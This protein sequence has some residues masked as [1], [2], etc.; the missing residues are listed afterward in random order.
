VN[1]RAHEHVLAIT[2]NIALALIAAA[3][4]NAAAEGRSSRPMDPRHIETGFKI[5][6]E[7]YCDQPYVIVND[8][9]SWTCVLTTGK[10][11]EGSRGQHIVSTISG[12]RGKTWS[13]LVDIE[14]A[15]GPESSWVVPLKAA[16][17]RIYAFYTYN[18]DNIRPGRSDT[19]G[20]YCYKYSDDNGRSWSAERYRIPM[21]ETAA[22][23][24]NGLPK[25][26][27]HFW[28]IDKPSVVD[29]VVY[30]AFTKLG[31]YF[32]GNGEGWVVKS[33]NIMTEKDPAKINWRILPDGDHG[34][35]HPDYGSIQEEHNI[36]PMSHESIYCVY[37]TTRGFPAVTISRDA[38]MTWTVPTQMRYSPGKRI[39]RTP[40]ACPKLWKCA[41]GKYLFWFHNNSFNHFYA[42]NPA[43]LIG[44]EERNGTIHWSEPEILLYHN[45]PRGRGTI[46]RGMSYPDLI[47]QDGRYWVTETVKIVAR[48]HEL[49]TTLL[50]GLWSQGKVKEVA[51][52]GL[53][54]AAGE[55]EI[56]SGSATL[57]GVDIAATA[58]MTIDFWIQLDDTSPGQTILDSRDGNG[59]GL[60]V[61][62]GNNG[63]IAIELDDGSSKAKWDSDAGLIKSDRR[64]HVAIVVDD[65]PRIV[66]FVIDGAFC[67]GRGKRQFGWTR[68]KTHLGDVTGSGTL[69]LANSLEE[70][71]V[72]GRYLR[73]SEVVA[74]YNAGASGR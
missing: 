45:T 4:I 18:G 56:A 36:V 68:Y 61:S 30:F 55:K 25:G 57:T 46:G 63:T 16:T 72:Y 26:C 52:R 2:R 22:D 71:R 67:D 50:E 20:W 58:G 48:V 44:G 24:T 33:D 21:R 51:S 65:G 13:P 39:V 17:G 34:L 19:H 10:G 74:N 31:K 64:H 12:N 14:P 9:A 32:L 15:T 29:G 70:L 40:R 54:L 7:G 27:P 60:V 42:R 3:G 6:D 38:G 41:N 73:T 53:L 8:D 59:R 66:S 62:T 43:W 69:K 5:P 37:R 47:E 35:R 23:R 49:D 1:T 11:H 28:G